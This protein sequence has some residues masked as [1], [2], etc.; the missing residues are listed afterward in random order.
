[1]Q[2]R[3]IS[4]SI[5]VKKKSI[6]IKICADSTKKVHEDNKGLK[7]KLRL[8][9]NNIVPLCQIDLDVLGAIF[10]AF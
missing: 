2:I 10:S 9:R 5:S 6:I 1:M 8:N 4:E 7:L 3:E